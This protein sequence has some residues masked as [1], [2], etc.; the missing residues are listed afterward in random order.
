MGNVFREE[1]ADSTDIH[2]SLL[3]RDPHPS[4]IERVVWH[5]VFANVLPIDGPWHSDQ[6]CILTSSR[7]FVSIG[8]E[9]FAL[10]V[11]DGSILW[12]HQ[13]ANTAIASIASNVDH[14]AILTLYGRNGFG[15]S[16]G[17]SNLMCVSESGMLLWCAELKDH[18]D[19]FVGFSFDGETLF[20]NTWEG[21]CEIIDPSSGLMIDAT[22][23][24]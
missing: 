6:V 5:K 2:V 24:K 16:E 3:Y 19:K 1:P 13:Y 10:S 17:R 12:R 8:S 22:W 4:R 14:R 20:A 7:A 15:P 21:W 11:T 18:Q 23:T 9:L